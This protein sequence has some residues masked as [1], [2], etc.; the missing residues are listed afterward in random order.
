MQSPS[1]T[2]PP[3]CWAHSKCSASEDR[4][5]RSHPVFPSPFPLLSACL[6]PHSLPRIPLKGYCHLSKDMA[7]FE[8]RGSDVRSK[9]KGLSGISKSKPKESNFMFNNSQH[10]WAQT[11]GF[12][13][14]FV[15]RPLDRAVSRRPAGRLYIMCALASCC[16]SLL[17]TS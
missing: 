6:H 3:L 7:I 2:F 5:T 17:L 11:C 1:P 14:G 13:N 8:R 4:R 10:D 12:I 16:G 9:V 15:F